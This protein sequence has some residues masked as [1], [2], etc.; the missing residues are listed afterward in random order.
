MAGRK[1]FGILGLAICASAVGLLIPWAFHIGGRLTPLY[2]S[3][4]GT[5]RTKNGTYPLYVLFY[6]AMERGNGLQGWGSL[7]TSRDK[8]L[9]LTVYGSFNGGLW[10]WSLDGASMDINLFEPQ[11]PRGEL[12]HPIDRGGFDLVGYWHG[13]ELVMNENGEHFTAFRSGFK[14]E[15]GVVTLKWSSKSD[16]NAACSKAQAAAPQ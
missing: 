16:F 10:T 6:P 8:V 5:L 14:V 2:W 3:G 11:G 12:F 7:C 1:K 15:Q 9:P 4:T 13:R